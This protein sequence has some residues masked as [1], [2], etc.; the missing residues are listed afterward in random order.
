MGASF[1]HVS[2]ISP[3]LRG[4]PCVTSG[5]QKWKGDSPNLMARAIVIRIDA[6]GSNNFM[7][8]HWLECIRLIIIASM[9]NEDAVACVKKYLAEASVARG[10]GFFI[11]MG[12]MA[13]MFISS[14]IQANNQWEL[15]VTIVVLRTSTTL[16]TT[17][18]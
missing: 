10:L 12:M 14:P 18:P 2:R 5:T 13:I 3:V 6:V 1:C 7:I 15:M 16:T 11:I 8:V 9:S 4:M 17:H